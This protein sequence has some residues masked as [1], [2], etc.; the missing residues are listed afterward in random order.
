MKKKYWLFLILII[1]LG[2]SRPIVEV[3]YHTYDIFVA[4]NNIG[5]VTASKNVNGS[6]TT[7]SVQTNLSFKLLE[8]YDVNY[9]LSSTYKNNY[10]VES[11]LKNM[12]NGSLQ[13][14]VHI[15][16]DGTQY[17]GQANQKNILIKEKINQSIAKLYF[18]EPVD[19]K[20]VF[21]EKYMSFENITTDTPGDYV[22]HLGDGNKSHYIYNNKVC[23]DVISTKSF[24][25][26]QFK[27]RP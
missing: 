18:Q 1:P 2:S 17:T 13:D 16:W 19:V 20:R 14:N 7:Y 24:F 26:I 21:S 23:T 5:K 27:L 11:A 8:T 15:K 6:M 4:E 12:V 25:K 3:Q 9:Q 10:L 22:L